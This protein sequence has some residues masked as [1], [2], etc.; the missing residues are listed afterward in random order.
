M[1][2]Q[3]LI[4]S[5]AFASLSS[6]IAHAEITPQRMADAIY[7]VI[8]SDRAVYTT[9]VVNRLQNEDE[10]ITADEHW[11][12]ESALPLPAQMLRMGAEGVAKQNAG[13][14]YALLSEWPINSQNSPKTP[15]E[16]QGLTFVRTNLGKNFY[17]TEELGG[18]KYFTAVYADMAVS[19]ACTKCHN[20]H[21][22]SPKT[23]F[24]LGDIM[25]GVVMRIPLD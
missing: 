17:G 14:T 19:E 9:Q 7:A 22:D 3:L 15:M 23:D 11:K 16:A 10:V 18:K 8:A 13:F 12:E 20:D 25:G 2:K 4:A 6:G 21:I 5:L 24:K 1:N